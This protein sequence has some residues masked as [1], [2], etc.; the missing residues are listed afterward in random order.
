MMEAIFLK[1]I[2]FKLSSSSFQGALLLVFYLSH[3]STN[4]FHGLFFTSD[5]HVSITAPLCLSLCGLSLGYTTSPGFTSHCNHL[6]KPC[7]VS[8]KVPQ[9]PHS[10]PTLTLSAFL[11]TYPN[12]FPYIP[13]MTEGTRHLILLVKCLNYSIFFP[14]PISYQ[15]P[16][17]SS[18]LL[19]RWLE[20]LSLSNRTV[21]LYHTA[22]PH[23]NPYLLTFHTLW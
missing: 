20:Y 9:T 1:Y 7:V 16:T 22:E 12:C 3:C 19:P 14:C 21:V 15:S 23:P 6:L 11:P 2:I 8:L 5:L 10:Q 13:I 18:V 4:S 17:P